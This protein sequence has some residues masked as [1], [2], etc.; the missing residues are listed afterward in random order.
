[1]KQFPIL[2]SL[3]LVCTVVL[4]AIS[5][6]Y[7]LFH[8]NSITKLDLPSVS[9]SSLRH[10]QLGDKTKEFASK[11]VMKNKIE[12]GG[13]V[14]ELESK[15]SMRN[16]YAYVTLLHGI[17]KSNRYRG[18]LYNA[19]IMKKALT[20]LGSTADF[21]VLVGFTFDKDKSSDRFKGDLELL[22]S[23]NIIVYILPRMITEVGKKSKISFA[24][25]A[26]LKIT[27]WSFI[28]Y[29]RLQ[30]LDGDV[31]PTK[32]MDCYFNLNINTFN[33]GSASPL[34]S[35][36]YLAIPN[37]TAYNIML[38]KAIWRLK[39]KWDVINGWGEHIPNALYYRGGD[40]AVTDWNFNGASLDQG[41]FT[42]HFVLNNGNVMLL[43]HS[44][45]YIYSTSYI[46]KTVKLSDILIS[47][48][49]KSPIHYFIHYT[50]HKKPWLGHIK[51]S[52]NKDVQVWGYHLD[53]LHLH[54]N[55]SNIYEYSLKS[56]LG[57]FHPNT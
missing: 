12:L 34:N 15:S 17:D 2:I 57:Y 35:G 4:L 30:Y 31:L 42:H 19:L 53:S 45:A 9:K 14:M 33:T 56:P 46:K 25:M 24:E 22:R 52:K 40:K 38:K 27:P 29:D 37:I 10:L 5:V 21:I 49:G 36:W 41:L 8:K 54:V 7:H 28:Q 1:M 23:S 48:S 11:S 39:S 50:G 18:F 13:K 32:N 43:D 26:L 6:F 47:C 3:F 44:E 51:G 20:D 55:S 16:K